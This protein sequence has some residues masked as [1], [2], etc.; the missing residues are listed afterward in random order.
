MKKLLPLIALVLFCFQDLMAQEYVHRAIVANGGAFGD[1]DP[2]TIGAYDP[3]TQEY[4][5]FDNIG[6]ESVQE[7][8]IHENLI[9]L[10]A[11]D[12]IIAYNY[13]TY[14]RVGAALFEGVKS[15]VV[16]GDY[17]Y[18]SGWFGVLDNQYIRMF[19][20][21]TLDLVDFG[22]VFN[23]T[24]D[25]LAANGLLYVAVPGPYLNST[26]TI[27]VIDAFDLSF[28]DVYD[29]G[30]DGAGLSNIYLEG[31]Y[32]YA[33]SNAWFEG[34]GKLFEINLT[35]DEVSTYDLALSKG[36]GIA[37]DLLYYVDDFSN[38]RT[39]DLNTFEAG[40]YSVLGAHINGVVNADVEALYLTTGNFA[41][42][43][44]CFEYNLAGEAGA[45]FGV[46]VS[47]EAVALD[48][49]QVVSN[50]SIE[51]NIEISLYPQPANEFLTVNSDKEITAY[52]LLSIDGKE[53][54]SGATN[55][56]QIQINLA[57]QNAGIYLLNM[58][59]DGE[60]VVRKVI[61]E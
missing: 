60:P 18:A 22:G 16:H 55:D 1:P 17:L 23:E 34:I 3:N 38:V 25:I 19:D 44:E 49:R 7:V 35:N 28:V 9:Y 14:E 52:Q 43:G 47:S 27:Q 5:I 50:E 58:V 24:A 39:Y 42:N 61:K 20:K 33:V 51:S 21:N 53:I 10:A 2:A 6:T 59:V 30:E 13:D 36:I 11:Q 56:N 4:T 32:L 46:G 26:A 48:V 31:N 41:T 57:D 15:L 37:N 45:S 8:I 29:L 54:V 40:P 12:S